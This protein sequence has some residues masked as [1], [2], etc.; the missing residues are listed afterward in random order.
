LAPGR[1]T[2]R[3][4]RQTAWLS[5]CC[6]LPST[7]DALPLRLENAAGAASIGAQDVLVAASKILLGRQRKIEV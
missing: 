6:S 2:W 4:A 7:A 3:P 5:P 1:G